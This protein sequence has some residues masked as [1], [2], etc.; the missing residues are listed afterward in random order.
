MCLVYGHV[1]GHVYEHSMNMCMVS[2]HVSGHVYGHMRMPPIAARRSHAF[3]HSTC[4][5]ELA[6]ACMYM[7]MCTSAVELLVAGLAYE[8]RLE[9]AELG[10]WPLHGT[11]RLAEDPPTV[12]AVVLPMHARV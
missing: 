3:T 6:G 4:T 1:S 12:P 10:Y 9:V 7:C 8:H 5:H 2:G 11:A